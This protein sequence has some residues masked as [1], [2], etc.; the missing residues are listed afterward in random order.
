[1]TATMRAAVQTAQGSADHL[2]MQQVP[3]PTP[4]PDEVRVRIHAATVT[5]GDAFMRK[6]PRLV[7]P[8]L[9]LMGFKFKPTPG[10][11]FAGVIDAVG[12]RVTAWKVGD[13]VFGTT[14]GL[15][16]GANAEAVCV[17]AVPKGRVLAHKPAALSFAQAAA[18]PVG[19]M[20]ALQILRRAAIQPGQR[21]LV[22][23]ASGS[24]GSYAVQIARHLGAEVTA[25][26]SAAN[27]ALV[28]SLGAETAAEY[29]EAGLAGLQGPFAVIFDAVGKTSRKQL[30][31]LLAAEGKWLSVK[32]LTNEKLADL[33]QLGEWAAQGHLRPA[34]DRCYPLEQAAEAHRL[35]DSGRKRGNVVIEVVPGA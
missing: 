9:G 13:A 4:K 25:V 21:V 35:V 5:S 32:T 12:E 24:V 31:H 16:A 27:F 20:T 18:L 28:R 14:T 17:P 19:G 2:Q 11:E 15:A 29:S 1:M 22:Y 23:G 33:A 26:C 30:G 8:L 3:M 6:L 10:H 34:I 7:Y